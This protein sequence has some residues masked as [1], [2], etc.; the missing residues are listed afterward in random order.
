MSHA[1]LDE[2]EELDDGR[3]RR[4]GRRYAA[5]RG[6]APAPERARRLL[7]HRPSP[8][9]GD[10]RLPGRSD[11]RLALRGSSSAAVAA[12]AGGPPARA[13]GTEL[14]HPSL[15]LRADA[16][17]AT[18][19]QGLAVT[20]RTPSRR[21][22][23]RAARIGKGG[24]GAGRPSTR[25][26]RKGQGREEVTARQRA[27]PRRAAPGDLRGQAALLLRTRGAGAEA[28]GHNVHLNGGLWWVLGPSG[29]RRS[30][31]R[32]TPCDLRQQIRPLDL[33][34]VAGVR[35]L[36]HRHA[37]SQLA[38]AVETAVDATGSFSPQ[39]RTRARPVANAPCHRS[40]NAPA[41][42]CSGSSRRRPMPTTSASAPTGRRASSG[43][44][45][46]PRKR[47]API[48]A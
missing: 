28:R 24:H 44:S 13:A 16:A 19:S 43:A 14:D 36:L 31:T 27:P 26:S 12:T 2:A 25:A 29:R 38:Q 34:V 10:Q 46:G 35:K 5:L 7:R 41:R 42:P 11:P 40:V 37:G 48:D 47:S 3:S 45:G 22:G 4:P 15:G 6:S 18:R 20:P 30:L 9:G 33:R 1:E 8:R 23:A 32:C 21:Q 39:A 17:A